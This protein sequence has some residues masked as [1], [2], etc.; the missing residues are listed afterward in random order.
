MSVTGG[1][2]DESVERRVR[3]RD[4]G[5]IGINMIAPPDFL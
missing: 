5:M 3:S 2:G 4:D 1:L